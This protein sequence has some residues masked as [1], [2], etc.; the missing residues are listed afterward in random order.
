[1]SIIIIISFS[2]YSEDLHLLSALQKLV[3][4]VLKNK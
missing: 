2:D 3:I 4:C 1:M